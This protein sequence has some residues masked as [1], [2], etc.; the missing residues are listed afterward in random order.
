MF[1]IFTFSKYYFK[2]AG[3]IYIHL[4]TRTAAGRY[5]KISMFFNILSN[6]AVSNGYEME[7]DFGIG[8]LFENSTRVSFTHLLHTFVW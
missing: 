7:Q 2:K 8:I 6:G 3:A 5:W 1:K 4:S